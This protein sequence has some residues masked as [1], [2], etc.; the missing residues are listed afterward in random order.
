[1]FK[2]HKRSPRNHRRILLTNKNTDMDT[3]NVDGEEM[4]VVCLEPV[5]SPRLFGLLPNCQHCVCV[6]CIRSWRKS[7]VGA[8]VNK[9]CP[10]CRTISHFY[11]PS[12]KWVVDAT[13]KEALVAKYVKRLMT[14]PCKYFER[15]LCR[16]G[17]RCYYGHLDNQTA[18]KR[19]AENT[20]RG[21]RV[22]GPREELL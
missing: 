5:T 4:C 20:H 9:R 3:E 2:R 18:P 22:Y 19:N 10:M 13:E 15:G 6:Q 1:M 11:I 21:V 7:D 8:G 14:V 17:A 16:Y 12:K